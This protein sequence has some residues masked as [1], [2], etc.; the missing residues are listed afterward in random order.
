M[1]RSILESIKEKRCFYTKSDATGSWQCV[2][3]W[4]H[5]DRHDPGLI[6]EIVVRVPK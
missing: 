1:T 4:G 2:K 6:K 5:K 3:E